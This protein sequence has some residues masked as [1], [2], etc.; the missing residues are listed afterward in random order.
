M[1]I[2]RIKSLQDNKVAVGYGSDGTSIANSIGMPIE[3]AKAMVANL[4]KGMP[5]MA[6]YKKKTVRFLKKNGYIV[7]NEYTGHRIYWPEWA[8]WKAEN[9]QFDDAFWYEYYA[10]HKGTGDAVDERVKRNKALG[11]DWFN[12]NVLNY[13]IQGGSAIVLKQAA[14]DL[15]KWVVDNGYFGKILFC[16]FVHDEICIECPES[17]AD[18][19]GKVLV[20]IMQNAAG[21]YY[22][23][24][25][26]PAEATCGKFWIH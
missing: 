13:P 21:K 24:L 10:V 5:G 23:K 9:D 15:F 16:V 14:A 3:K 7:I 6:A 22:K 8:V 26:I 17:I 25:P 1:Q 18:T 19:F 2:C 4:L 20:R 12:K 11:H